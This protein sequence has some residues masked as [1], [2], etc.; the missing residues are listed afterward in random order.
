MIGTPIYELK[1]FR[2]CLGQKERRKEEWIQ[3]PGFGKASVEKILSAINQASTTILDKVIAA[4]GIP[5]VG[6]RVAK[7]LASHYKTWKSFREETDFTH[8]D[9]IG[10]VMNNNLLSFNYSEIDYIVTNYLHFTYKKEENHNVL[11]GKTFCVTG[12]THIYPNRAGLTETIENMGGRVVGS[13]SS[14]VNYLINNDNTST[15]AKNIAAI[16]AGIPI[17]TEE[18]LQSMMN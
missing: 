11:E 12:K 15:S 10:D 8:L 17:L 13:M 14:K 5:E 18:D 4:A 1:L 16:Q 7:D 6:S 9:G 3:K 2:M